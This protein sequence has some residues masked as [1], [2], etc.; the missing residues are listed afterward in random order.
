MAGSQ[1][2][3]LSSPQTLLRTAAIGGSANPLEVLNQAVQGNS[4]AAAQAQSSAAGRIAD[5]LVGKEPGLQALQAQQM[6]QLAG[7]SNPGQL[8][9][10]VKEAE[11]KG[12]TP[13]QLMTERSRK[14]ISATQ[15]AAANP[16]P[17]KFED[18]G[19]DILTKYGSL[20]DTIFSALH[21]NQ[22]SA[23]KIQ[24]SEFQSKMQR[25]TAA[26]GGRIDPSLLA[27]ISGA[28]EKDGDEGLKKLHIGVAGRRV[29]A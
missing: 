4:L 14:G 8:I 25:I 29:S 16:P 12:V 18:V 5:M 24:G 20:T 3:S 26:L 9:N 28:Y 1:A 13:S 11:D 21:L 10:L 15:E 2:Q 6:Y 23:K 17:I 7:F 27:A 22:D 19:P